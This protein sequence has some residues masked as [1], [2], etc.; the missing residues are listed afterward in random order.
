MKII[1]NSFVGFT[2][3]FSNKLRS[4][5][6]M[7][8][9]IIGVAA[10]IGTIAIGEGARTLVLQEVEKVGGRT[11]FIV[12]RHDWINKDGRWM[13]NPSKEYL[14][15]KDAQAIEAQASAVKEVTPEIIHDINANVEKEGRRYMIEA[16][17]PTFMESQ[18]WFLDF[19]RFLSR[20]DMGNREKVAI[21]G[22]KVWE[23]M[24]NK[25]NPLGQEIR[26]G[27]ERFTVVGVMEER[28]T[29]FGD[30]DRDREIII[31]LTTDQKRFIG[32]DLVGM[33]WGKA[34]SFDVADQAVLEAKTILMRRHNDEEFF[35]IMS[36][37]GM[38]D[39]INKIILVIKV[40]LGG[41]AAIA[42]MVGGVGIMNIMLVSV[43]E[44]T[45]E[46]GLRKAVGAKNRDILSQFLVEAVIL[47]I[48]GGMI[49]ILV[50]FGLG[51]GLAQIITR[52]IKEASWPSTVSINSILFAVGSSALI[53]IFFGLYPARKASKL[54]PVEALRYE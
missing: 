21:I 2:A 37:K 36:V 25:V 29:A 52:I 1:E 4:F 5:L 43:T 42:L 49:G 34:K 7:L 48:V 31:P 6:T 54:A 12:M 26:L 41:T 11:L 24:F 38:L 16:T 14:T 8:G 50:G 27:N 22:A 9:I 13:R 17:V 39:E 20:D 3:I 15:S 18:S 44:R 30:L 28:G 40:M 32:R 46:I 47:C 53:G 23:E 35:E 45:R 51:T 33:F 10:V 19:G